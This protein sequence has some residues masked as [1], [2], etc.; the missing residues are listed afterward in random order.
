MRRSL[1]LRSSVMRQLG[2]RDTLPWTARAPLCRRGTLRLLST[3]PADEKP[4]RGPPNPSLAFRQHLWRLA[5][6]ERQRLAGGLVLL[7]GSSSI[8]V[9]FPKVMGGVM[10]ACLAG[11]QSG[12]TP[13]TAAGAFCVL[14][15]VQSG[16]VATR[17][18]IL[19]VS[20]ERVAARLRRDT[21]ASLLRHDLGFF[22]RGRT[23]ELTSRLTSDCSSLQKLVV[24][25]AVSAARA[26]LLLLGSTVGMLSLS[27]PL[28]AV[29]VTTFPLA[30]L[31]ARY[32]SVHR[33]ASHRIASH[34]S[35]SI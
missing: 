28:F 12:W 34:P 2:A 30:V 31:T 15:G 21:F 10:D 16:M 18:R 9:T 1:Q 17:G 6:P 8:S 14:L 5:W 7:A 32:I 3:V 11:A 27:P 13:A 24:A 29:S 35:H 25:D 22:E 33:I 19:A 4:P 23:G 26:S 20:A